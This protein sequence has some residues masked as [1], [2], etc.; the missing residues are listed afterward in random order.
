VIV[1]THAHVV[2]PD[3]GRY[4]LTRRREGTEW[5]TVRPVPAETM[6]ALMDHAGIGRTIL[7]QPVGAYGYDNRYVVD[8]AA[9]WPGRFLAVA[10]VD[11]ASPVAAAATEDW[12]KRGARS[13]RVVA[14]QVGEPWPDGNGPEEVWTAAARVAVPICVHIRH[15][16]LPALARLL[17]DFPKTAVAADHAAYPDFPTGGYGKGT[18]FDLTG[19]ANAYVKVSSMTL[20]AAGASAPTY[21]RRLV[22]AFG[23]RRILWGS[24]YSHTY[25]PD[26]AGQLALAQ[27]AASLLTEEERSWFLG[28]AA[29]GL[30]RL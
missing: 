15:P 11:L 5:V 29:A 17:R 20:Q 21:L 3:L 22:D 8:S 7:V 24:D 4:P 19:Y 10:A 16:V 23:K 6:L 9:R 26:L 14:G 28:L 30:W 13:I 25:E 2:S 27:Q 18:F 1:D 12:V